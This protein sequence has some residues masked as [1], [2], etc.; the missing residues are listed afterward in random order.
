M[1]R[2]VKEPYALTLFFLLIALSQGSYSSSGLA[3]FAGTR[4]LLCAGNVPGE[5][6]ES[7]Y[8]VDFMPNM[9]PSLVADLKDPQSY[10][11]LSQKKFEAVIAEYCPYEVDHE[12]RKYAASLVAPDGLYVGKLCGKYDEIDSVRSEL[13]ASGFSRVLF[14]HHS[15]PRWAKRATKEEIILAYSK[16]PLPAF[17]LPGATRRHKCGGTA[18]T[19]WIAFLALK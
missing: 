1:L 16:H 7:F 6:N 17:V 15:N 18:E 14:S 19:V 11:Y 3:N 12:I 13:L 2:S 8:T 4:L 5:N 10:D 9:F